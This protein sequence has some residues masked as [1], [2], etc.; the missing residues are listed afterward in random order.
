MIIIKTNFYYGRNPIIYQSQQRNVGNILKYIDNE[1]SS[2]D[3][4]KKII[5]LIH[6][7]EDEVKP[8]TFRQLL[9]LLTNISMNHQ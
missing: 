2:T 6:N 1:D 4:F 8:E 3:D 7:G 9:R 5:D